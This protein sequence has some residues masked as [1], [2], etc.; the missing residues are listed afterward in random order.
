G[1]GDGILWTVERKDILSSSPG[2]KPAVLYAYDATN[3]A[4]LL[5]D[6]AQASRLRDQPGCANKFVTPTVANGKGFVGT[7][8]ELDVYG[9]LPVPRT[10]PV[11]T[12]SLVCIAVTGQTV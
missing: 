2:T 8:N 9:L 10:T 3:V 1:T 7:Q 4:T 6:S 12:L 5:Y 11:P